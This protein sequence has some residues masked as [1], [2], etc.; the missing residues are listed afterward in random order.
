MAERPVQAFREALVR[1]GIDAELGQD[2]CLGITFHLAKSREE[3]ILEAR[4]YFQEYVKMFGPLGFLGPLDDAQA[5]AIM[6]RSG[7]EEAGVPTIEDACAA[8]SWF[9]GTPE[10]FVEYLQALESRYP[11]LEDVNVAS[12]M[13]T[14]E[15]VMIE[16]LEWFAADVMPAMTAREAAD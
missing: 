4:P 1:A 8:G 7:W 16:Q 11:G 12:S 6:T 2:L 13:G 5:A 15:A 14:P 10:G 9:C 3:A